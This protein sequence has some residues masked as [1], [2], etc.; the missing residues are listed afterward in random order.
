LDKTKEQGPRLAQSS[1]LKNRLPQDLM[2]LLL[3]LPGGAAPLTF[4]NKSNGRLS[5]QTWAYHGFAPLAPF[6][7]GIIAS[8]NRSV[9]SECDISAKDITNFAMHCPGGPRH[10][11]GSGN[12]V[13]AV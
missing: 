8:M 7:A 5:P 4:T 2:I 13:L 10:C 9:S 12:W 3:L 6:D 11:H 1:S